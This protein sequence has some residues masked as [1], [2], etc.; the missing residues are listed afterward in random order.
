MTNISHTNIDATLFE[1]KL[2]ELAQYGRARCGVGFGK[3]PLGIVYALQK[4]SPLTSSDAVKQAL[5][6]FEKRVSE[7]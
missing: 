6:A 3:F 1:Q 7:D 2:I 4:L 5:A